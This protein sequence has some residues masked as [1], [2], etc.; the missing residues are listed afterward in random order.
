MLAKLIGERFGNGAADAGSIDRDV[1]GSGD[2]G[3][4]DFLLLVV[5]GFLKGEN[6]ARPERVPYSLQRPGN[7]EVAV[8]SDID[9]AEKRVVRFSR[10]F[11]CGG[12]MLGG[13]NQ[14][15]RKELIARLHEVAFVFLRPGVRI[16]EVGA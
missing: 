7:G 15:G 3:S 4:K 10:P 12:G 6:F 14:I 2:A 13:A 9:A 8:A 1:C 5:G 16:I 11:D